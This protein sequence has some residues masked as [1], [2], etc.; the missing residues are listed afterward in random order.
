MKTYM[1][2]NKKLLNQKSRNVGR[3]SSINSSASFFTTISN[4][5][6]ES[7]HV[8]MEKIKQIV[9]NK[10]NLK[11]KLQR[12]SLSNQNIKMINRRGSRNVASQI[13]GGTMPHKTLALPSNITVI[14]KQLITIQPPS[15]EECVLSD[16]D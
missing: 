14:E 8:N 2:D 10:T 11:G 12:N 13:Q 4:N 7:S 1:D 6:S 15:E 16:W 5:D 3:N 9:N